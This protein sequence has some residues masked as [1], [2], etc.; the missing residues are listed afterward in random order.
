[1]RSKC[2]YL[3][4]K[5]SELRI[6]LSNLYNKMYRYCTTEQQSENLPKLEL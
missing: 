2:I 4:N 1:M 3:Y 5:I 6:Y